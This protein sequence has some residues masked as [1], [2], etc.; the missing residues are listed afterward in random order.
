MEKMLESLENLLD[1]AGETEY[2]VDYGVRAWAVFLI[3]VSPDRVMS[4][5]CL[6][7][8]VGHARN[9]CYQQ[10]ASQQTNMAVFASQVRSSVPYFDSAARRADVPP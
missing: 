3:V 2:E 1:E 4:E 10:A 6:D 5:R 8:E 7:I 9:L